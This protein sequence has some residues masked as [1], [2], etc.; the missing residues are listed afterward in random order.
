MKP[1][2]DKPKTQGGGCKDGEISRGGAT[3]VSDDRW[4]GGETNSRRCTCGGTEM[5][6]RGQKR[7]GDEEPGVE[8]VRREKV[9]WEGLGGGTGWVLIHERQRTRGEGAGGQVGCCW[10]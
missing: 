2:V 1:G 7:G 3:S 4:R 8:C 10:Y 9:G 5:R 6:Q